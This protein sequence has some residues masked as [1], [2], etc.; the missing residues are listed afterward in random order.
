MTHIKIKK[1][2][3]IRITGEP[4]QEIHRG[5]IATQVAVV[6]RD[7]V[8]LKPRMLVAEGDSVTLG[9][10]LFT[11]RDNKGVQFV[12]PGSGRIKAVH[13]GQR[14]ILQS[15]VI[16]L[17]DPDQDEG[18][19]GFTAYSAQQLANAPA[20]EVREQLINSGLWVALR[21]RPFSRVPAVDAVPQAIFVSAMDTNPLTAD[22]QVVIGRNPEHFQQGLRV[23]GRLAEVPVHLGMEHGADITV[24]DMPRLNVSTYSGPHPAGLVGTHIHFV[25]PVGAGRTVWTIGYQ[26]VVA[27][28]HLFATGQSMTERVVALCGPLVENP[29]LITT[30]LGAHTTD[31]VA[32]EVP[33]VSSRVIAGSVLSGRRAAGWG[34]YLGRRHNQVTVLAEGDQ[35]EFMGWIRP[36]INKYS[37]WRIYLANLFRSH[38]RFDLNTSQ[39]GSERAMVPTG[40]YEKVMPQDYLPTQLLRAL[41][42]KDTVRAQE[43]GCLELHEEDLALCTFVC[44]S[45][46]EYGPILRANL[47]LIE[48]EG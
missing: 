13:R 29:R 34:A 16:K 48:K 6:G 17:D 11:D 35:R 19:G 28:G 26:D 27:I 20:Q 39:N 43:L 23:L 38:A 14:R 8:G 3:D 36:G 31:I 1:G 10:P 30:R 5:N 2:L 40:Q 9:Q 44:P 18:A 32:N 47:D 42:V 25:H 46:Y 21:T 12:A 15:V 24:P 7:F 45:K 37:A 22:P 33:R 41:L 4:V